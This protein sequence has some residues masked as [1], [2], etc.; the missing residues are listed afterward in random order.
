MKFDE[1]FE[2]FVK[3]GSTKANSSGEK[4]QIGKNVYRSDDISQNQVNLA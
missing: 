3:D 1:F 4:S 2:N